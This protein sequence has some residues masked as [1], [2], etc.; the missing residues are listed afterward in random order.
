M[1][2]ERAYDAIDDLNKNDPI[3]LFH[4]GITWPSELLY[5]IRMTQEIEEFSPESSDELKVAVRAQHI[6]RWLSP[7][8]SYPM[9]KAGYMK[10]RTELYGIHAE[11]AGNQLRKAGFTDK[12]IAKVATYISEKVKRNTKETQVVEDVACL[13]FLRWYF[14]EFIVKHDREKLISIV[15]K[16]W[17]KMSDKAHER[18]L[19]I[20]FPEDQLAIIQEALAE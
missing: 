4:N 16:T 20:E 3:S 14:D 5:G 17:A 7:R 15:K 12:Y 19:Q 6:G 10:W 9:D 2:I 11:L 1:H 8:S 13:V 18:A